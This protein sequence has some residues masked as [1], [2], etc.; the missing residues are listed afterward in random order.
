[1]IGQ[2]LSHFKIT[3]KLGEGGMGEVYRAEDTN[4][5]REVAIKVLP[6]EFSAD[7]ERLA[8]FEREAK[9]LAALNHPNIA[10]IFE[11]DE[12]T[13]EDGAKFLFLA[14]ELAEG[15][16]LAERLARGPMG[17]DEALAAAHQIAMA[18][19]AAHE[20]G[21]VHRD[22]K[23]ANI[24]LASDGSGSSVK[25][26][27]FGLAK[28]WE[29]G[30]SSPDMTRSPTLT[31]QMTQ[32]GVILGTAGYMS[33][34]Q[35]RAQEADRR[36]DI[37][38]FGV[39]FYEMLTGQRLFGADTVSD[40]LA[41]VLTFEPSWEELD[42]DLPAPLVALLQRCLDRDASQ[43]LQAIGEARIAIEKIRAGDYE[44]GTAADDMAPAAAGTPWLPWAIAG[45]AAATA[46][47]L[48]V[49]GLGST[50]EP[51]PLL[52]ASINPPD[53]VI[54]EP[55]FGLA[56]SPDGQYIVMAGRGPGMTP[57]IEGV[58]AASDLSLWLRRVD[59]TDL[60]EIPRTQGGTYPFWSPDSR[61]IG[62]FADRKLKRVDVQGSPPLTLATVIDSR[63]GSWGEDD[64]IVYAPDFRGGL[65]SLP[66]N[67]GTPQPIADLDASRGEQSLRW[68]WFLPGGTHVLFLAQTA[69]GGAGGDT[70]TIEVL[71]IATGERQ[72]VLQINSSMAYDGNGNLLYWRDGALVAQSFDLATR[73]VEGGISP[74][75]EGI[76]YTQN[77]Q[78]L[79]SVS[80]WGNLVYQLGQRGGRT[81]PLFWYDREG[82]RLEQAGPPAPYSNMN[83]SPDG[84][85]LV[86][87]Q[88]DGLWILDLE[89]GATTRLTEEGDYATPIWSP[90][91]EWIAYRTHRDGPAELR[92]RPSSGMGEEELLWTGDYV[93]DLEAWSPDGSTLLVSMQSPTSA[94]DAGYF[95]LE[96]KEIT[97][98]S[99][100]A[101][102]EHESQFSPDGQWVAFNSDETG[103][104][105]IFLVRTDGK[106]RR[107]Q[108]TTSEGDFPSFSR[109][110]SE[111]IF[112]NPDG[113][114]YSV[115]LEFD[116]HSG[117]A[118]A[119]F[120]DR[121]FDIG[122]V[123][124]DDRWH[125]VGKDGRILVREFDR[126]DAQL[127]LRLVQN[128]QQILAR[129]Q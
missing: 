35:A 24:K 105:E 78:A 37:W 23:P 63:G 114:L 4:L 86:Y 65:T 5:D 3:A 56:I 45:V 57:T 64:T 55:S 29:A 28:A 38:S 118:K 111:L 59:S 20:R 115:A 17:V 25:V 98:F 26:L 41:R 32:A 36:S 61:H 68:P 129:R 8:R 108:I 54:L 83:L 52:Q 16:D 116:D 18:L 30:G 85:Q 120:P 72:V 123:P 124:S 27:D 73:Q 89:R 50:A 15:E 113:S 95:S 76:G 126:S 47:V 82:N 66:A 43:R 33:P 128:W 94:W 75:V 62:F 93:V 6:K 60:R 14:M 100:S 1:L 122:Y 81:A 79:F 71:E 31:A 125:L 117:V 39:V 87:S 67:G 96:T 109:D 99:T 13:G 44:A 107:L 74:L 21:V 22:L 121:L 48:G 9:L 19:E 2:T 103:L 110:G 77:E 58:R 119:G 127:P 106:G 51:I 88:R 46:I 7:P 12:A 102:T 104:Y 34:E 101:G 112:T 91:G 49:F 90:D 84:S 70:S 42:V 80:T 97:P 53:E 92:R 69:E 11:V 10:G 40:T